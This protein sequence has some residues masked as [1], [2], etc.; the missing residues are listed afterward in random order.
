MPRSLKPFEQLPFAE[1]PE[2]PRVAHPYFSADQREVTVRSRHFGPVK[3]HVSVYGEGPPLLLLHGLMTASYSFRYVMEPLARHFTL[4]IPDLVGG[5][6]SDKPDTTYHPDDLARSVGELMHELGIWGAPAIGNSMGGYLLMRL[7][8][9]EPGAMSRL[10]NLHSPGLPTARMYA[11]SAVSAVPSV[12][13][14]VLA[15]LVRL[16]PER[17]VHQNV[18]YYDESLKSCEEHR[19][20]AGA[21]TSQGGLIG[22]ARHLRDTLAVSEMRR[23]EQTLKALERFP[24]PLLLVYARQDKMVPPVVGE[25]LARLIP[26]ARIEWLEEA[27]HFAHVDAPEAFL[28]A[29]W[30][31]LTTTSPLSAPAE[32]LQ[33]DST[34]A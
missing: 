3:M 11:L 21:L 23:F 16:N 8:L 31:F 7:A 19:E 6:R 12:F 9:L 34:T 20:Y 24:I 22:L 29:A 27:S 32:Y 17:W 14:S 5:G 30:P 26:D 10:V 25:R 13:D 28:R 18:H 15:T 1:V 4:Y 2:E 33:R